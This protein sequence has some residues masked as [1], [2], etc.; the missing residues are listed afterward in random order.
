MPSVNVPHPIKARPLLL[1]H[2]L[3]VVGLLFAGSPGFAAT[4]TMTV[5]ATFADAPL[6]FDALQF[7]NVAG[8]TVSVSRC[9]LLLSD[10]AFRRTDG[11][12]LEQTNSVALLKLAES[13]SSFHLTEIPTGQFDQVRF[14]V[15][16]SQAVNHS[17]VTK[18]PADHPLNPNFNGLHWSW[19]GGYI[20]TALEGMWSRAGVA[21]SGYSL[22]FANDWNLTRVT[23]PTKLDLSRDNSLPL[24]LDVAELLRAISF[25]NDG[26]ST[27]AREGDPIAAKLKE[28]FSKA[29]RVSSIRKEE[30][31]DALATS[32]TREQSATQTSAASQTLPRFMPA[33]FTPYRFTMS[34]VFPVPDLPKDNPLIEERVALGRALFHDAKLSRDNSISCAS[35]HAENAAFSDARR[36][37]LGVEGRTGKR[38]AMPLFNLAWKSSFFW[39]GRAPSLRAQALVPIQ[40]HAEMDEKLERVVAKL[41]GQGDYRGL[42]TAAFGSAE[43]TPE[44]IGLAIEA[45][46]LTLTSFDSKFDRAMRGEKVALTV[47]EQRGFELFFT[48]Y[49]PRREQFGADCF[50]CHGG[51]NFS[52]HGFANNGLDETFADVGRFAVTQRESDRGKFSVPSLRNVS[53]TAPYMHDGRFNTLEEVI[54]HYSTGVKRSTTL[55]PNLAKHPVGGMNLSTEDKAALVAFLKTLTEER[56]QNAAG[57]SAR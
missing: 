1:S 39:D 18:Y 35:C 13:R 12:W 4:L 32:N 6:R 19:Q 55:D 24:D 47:E 57:T 37:S 26:T 48:E 20:F 7:T 53:L 52:T 30:P 38:Q 22:H 34:S 23:L 51:A 36:F 3:L 56:W 42:F 2:A 31:R 27:H 45:F 54:D 50:H 14:N 21:A 15:G 43:I 10:F 16:V 40:D 25:S 17:D 5:R 33:K 46:V 11:V 44:K 29:F 8:E 9:D 41:A 28:S 49:D